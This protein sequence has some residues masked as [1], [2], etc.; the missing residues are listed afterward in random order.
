MKYV[1]CNRWG[2][3]GYVVAG[4]I[5]SIIYSICI[6]TKE[7]TIMDCMRHCLESSFCMGNSRHPNLK[8]IALGVDWV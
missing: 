6:I 7:D 8:N 3:N 2:A 4:S 1:I 5:S